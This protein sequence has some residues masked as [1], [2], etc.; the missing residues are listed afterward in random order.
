MGVLGAL[1]LTVAMWLAAGVAALAIRVVGSVRRIGLT[2]LAIA[3]PE[4]AKD[5]DGKRIALRTFQNT[6]GVWTRGIL[7][8]DYGVDLSSIQW[9]TQDEEETPWPSKPTSPRMLRTPLSCAAW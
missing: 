2:N 3:F 6:A 9:F 7:A 1:P 5:L 4:N 8:D